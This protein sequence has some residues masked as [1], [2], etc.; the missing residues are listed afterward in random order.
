MSRPVAAVSV[1]SMRITGWVSA[2]AAFA[3]AVAV[4]L[5]CYWRT[6]QSLTWA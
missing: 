3:V 6:V 1:Y 2:V 4:L 5:A